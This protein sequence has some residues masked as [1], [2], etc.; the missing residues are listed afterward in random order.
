MDIETARA[1]I[2]KHLDAISETYWRACDTAGRALDPADLGGDDLDELLAC[3]HE[4]ALK[5]EDIMARDGLSWREAR[6]YV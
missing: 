6:D 3:E 1:R 5:V 4:D 2:Q